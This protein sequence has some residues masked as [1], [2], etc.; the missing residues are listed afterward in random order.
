MDHFLPELTKPD[1]PIEIEI[2]G[3]RAL[4]VTVPKPIF[5]KA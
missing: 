2:R 1:A 4:A 5:R 3:K